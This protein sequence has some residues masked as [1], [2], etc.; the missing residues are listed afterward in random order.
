M[1]Y[2]KLQTSRALLVAV[3]DTVIIP[4][5][6]TLAVSGTNSGTGTNMLKDAT[7]DFITLGVKIGDIVYK[8]TNSDAAYVTSVSATQLGL[9]VDLYP[10][11]IGDEYAIYS[12]VNQEGCVLYIGS[13]GNLHV[14]TAGGDD[15]TFS[16]VPAGFF[17]VQVK[18]VFADTTAT[19]IVAL[20]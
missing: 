16:G 9:S 4:N 18:Q 19:K 17:P 1:A 3:S 12:N 10:I 6:N 15:I 5:P 2:Q 13:S 11:T 7:K 8:N 14:L 20:W